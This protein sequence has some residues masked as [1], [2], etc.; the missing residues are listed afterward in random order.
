MNTQEK[1]LLEIQLTIWFDY[2]QGTFRALP[3]EESPPEVQ[4]DVG[5]DRY[6]EVTIPYNGE[7]ADY[8]F[9]CWIINKRSY[10][11]AIFEIV[12]IKSLIHELFEE[13]G[14]LAKPMFPDLDDLSPNLE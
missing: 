10:E 9:T 13:Y 8:G 2:E 5:A 7:E 11:I 1:P 4:D 3:L 6:A 12:A 14:H